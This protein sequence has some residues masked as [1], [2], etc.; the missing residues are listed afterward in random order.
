M[1]AIESILLFF[2]ILSICILPTIIFICCINNDTSKIKN[3][4]YE[5]YETI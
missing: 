1:N 2:F 4:N 3:K 5:N